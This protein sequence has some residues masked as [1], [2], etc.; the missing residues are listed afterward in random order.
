MN[1]EAPAPI[2]DVTDLCFAH[3]GEPAL[4]AA[5][6]ATIGAGV[7]LLYGDTGSGKST[8]L[9]VM[10]GRVPAEG[11]LSLAGARLDRQPEAYR[12]NVF[13]CD[14]RTDAFDELT[15]VDCAASL[16][17]DDARFS[18]AR[19][20]ACVEA[21]ALTP[22]LDKRMSMLSTGSRRKVLLAAALASGRALILLDEPTGG[23]DAASTRFFWRTLT[24]LA[25]HSDQAI[26]VAS[27]SRIDLV[28]LSASIELSLH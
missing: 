3:P 25:D 28:P 2:L 21:F 11:R 15:A 9:R 22:H 17:A 8:L 18:E 1:S 12:R 5:W 4:A 24:E 16:N 23:L 7:T 13:F 19:W 10:A 14:P 20:R 26:L 27:G 6:C